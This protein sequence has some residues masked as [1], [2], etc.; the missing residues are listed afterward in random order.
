MTRAAPGETDLVLAR[1]ALKDAQERYAA[2]ARRHLIAE[3]AALL[4]ER[5]QASALQLSAEYEYDDE[6]GY[7][8]CLYG[9]LTL[10]GDADADELDDSWS[11]ALDV[12]QSVVLELFGIESVGDGALTRDQLEALADREGIAPTTRAP[13]A[14]R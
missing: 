4:R 2:T 14:G 1:E 13:G 8:R 12:E 9:S 3:L 11:E 7:M 6:G 5:P 10:H